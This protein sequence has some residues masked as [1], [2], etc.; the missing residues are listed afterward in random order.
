MTPADPTAPPEP[1]RLVG[2]VAKDAALLADY[3]RVC[4]GLTAYPPGQ[5]RYARAGHDAARRMRTRFMRRHAEAVYDELTDGGS[6]ALRLD[7]LVYAAAESYPGLVPTR[8]QMA[9]EALR[10]Q[11]EKEGREID[12]GIFFH[13]ILGSPRAGGH[14]MAGMLRPTP[15][16]V[17][18]LP[19]FRRTGLLELAAV[20]LERR[21]GGAYLTVVNDHCLNAEDNQHVEDMETAVDLALL[22]PEVRVGVLRGGPMTH[23]RYR[24]RRVFSAGINL[25]DLHEGRISYVDFLLRRELGYIHK[26]LRG[27]SPAADEDV[28]PPRLG[29]KPWVAVV[30]TFAIGGGAQLL[31]VFDRVIAAAD[32]YLSLPAA[33]EGIV[34]GAG[35]FRLGRLAGGRVSRQVILWG[36]KI[37]AHEP[38]AR[39]LVD[40]VV[41]PRELDAAADAAVERLSA[42]AVLANKR[43]LNLAEEPVDRFGAYMAEFALQQALRLY[44]DDV[45]GKVRRFSTERKPESDG[46][47]G[48]S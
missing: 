47:A 15:R 44:A 45:L 28:W 43:M 36:R 26:L 34:P 42:P 30:D 6:D 46:A 23:P 35:N 12:Q 33:Q 21:D 9:G 37:W 38:D 24:G 3:V 18:L 22:D 31:M 4:E 7:E 17:E 19:E 11:A 16:A 1:P 32:A 10:V 48:P 8:E 13:A 5:R 14:L 2:D 20:H 27:L 39:L 25:A 40:E 41:D 29:D